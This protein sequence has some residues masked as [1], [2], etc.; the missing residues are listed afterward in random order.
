MCCGSPKK[1]AKW[2]REG[3]RPLRMR[4]S[5]MRRGGT[6][7]RRVSRYAEGLQN[8]A[9]KVAGHCACAA[10]EC[11]EPVRLTVS[12]I[13]ALVSSPEAH[14]SNRGSSPL[15][16]HRLVKGN[17]GGI[18][19]RRRRCT[20]DDGQDGGRQEKNGGKDEMARRSKR[21]CGERGRASSG[22]SGRR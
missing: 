7:L 9:E 22:D 10:P 19:R 14:T 17:C 4:G 13:Q 5:R 3:C 1:P 15:P 21:R 20:S 11:V 6:P 2:R 18:R 12:L 16:A 8:G